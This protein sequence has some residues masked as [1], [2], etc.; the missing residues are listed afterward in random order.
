MEQYAKETQ[1]PLRLSQT[2][3]KSKSRWS[4][5][6]LLLASTPLDVAF[7]E[8]NAFTAQMTE[9]YIYMFSFY[10]VLWAWSFTRTDEWTQCAS[11]PLLAWLNV[12]IAEIRSLETASD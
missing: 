7:K 10:L 6:K 9:E 12:V 1:E 11:W 8:E 3:V 2:R 4:Q 5:W